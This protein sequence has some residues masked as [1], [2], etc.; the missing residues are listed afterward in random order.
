MGSFQCLSHSS[1]FSEKVAESADRSH[2]L[3]Q[4]CLSLSQKR[5]DLNSPRWT[6]NKK[7]FKQLLTISS[8]FKSKHPKAASAVWSVEV[9][10]NSKAASTTD[11]FK[12]KLVFSVISNN[13]QVLGRMEHAN[14][15]KYIVP[16]LRGSSTNSAAFLKNLPELDNLILKGRYTVPK[17]FTKLGDVSEKSSR[18]SLFGVVTAVNKLPTKGAKFWHSLVCLSD[19]SL[20]A[21]KDCPPT[22]FK[23]HIYLALESDFPEIHLGDVA[24]FTNVKV[25][26]KTAQYFM[27]SIGIILCL[28]N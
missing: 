19:P 6:V 13:N 18:P 17:H 14:P 12:E 22:E 3:R 23:M 21:E 9:G 7:E 24:R 10:E 5:Y 8:L 28:L 2:L 20:I 27:N 16:R 4:F 15:D 11:A 26:L 1:S 25:T